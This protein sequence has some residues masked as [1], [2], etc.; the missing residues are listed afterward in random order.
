MTTYLPLFARR[1][2]S[3]WVFLSIALVAAFLLTACG[4]GETT[5]TSTPTATTQPT[6]APTPTTLP[7]PTPT[8]TPTVVTVKIVE[9]NEMYSFQPATL[10]IKVGT[11]VVWL[12]TSDAPHTVTSDTAGT[13]SSP[14]NITQ[15]KTFEFTFTTAGT[16]PYHCSIHPYMKATI[17]VTS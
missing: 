9:Q 13:F 1:K 14:A 16:F 5:T 6:P 11:Q 12:N 10:T 8:P 7:S 17:T 4:G 3:L 2:R 15:N